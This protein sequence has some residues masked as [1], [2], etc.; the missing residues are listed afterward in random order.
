MTSVSFSIG[1]A[2]S[3]NHL[4]PRNAQFLLIPNSDAGRSIAV[5]VDLVGIGELVFMAWL[6]VR[7]VRLPVPAMADSRK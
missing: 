7:S 4:F 3:I 5:I 6:L 2:S 1:W